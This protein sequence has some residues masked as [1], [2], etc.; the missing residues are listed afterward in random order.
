MTP[1]VISIIY[2]SPESLICALD[3]ASQA[4]VVVH[5]IHSLQHLAQQWN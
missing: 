4:E 5:S 1:F 2:N 3:D